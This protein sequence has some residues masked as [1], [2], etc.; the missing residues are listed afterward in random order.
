MKFLAFLVVFFISQLAY[1]QYYE[2]ETSPNKYRFRYKSEVYKGTRLEITAKLRAIK[3][4]PKF[5]GIPEE[6]QSGLNKLFKDA[7]S[8][9]LP[10]RYRKKA[11]IFLDAL[12]NYEEFVIMYNGALYEVVEK[13]K[14]DIKRIDFKLERQFIKSKTALDRIKKTDSTNIQEI[15][16]LTEERQKSLI[17]LASHRWMKKKFE[18]Y[19]GIDMVKNPDDLIN[20]FKKAEAGYI[21]SVFGQ[22]SVDEIKKYLENQII[23]FYYK[24]AII[25]IDPE[26]LDL[27]YINKYN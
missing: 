5:S 7:K 14:R 20:E 8:Q 4:G 16:Y 2:D 26:K 9:A 6:I 22:K 25:E 13:L 10:K 15:Q 17:R 1:N 19:K 12:Y 23:D 18:A 3:N 11:I 24:K 21:F 27:Q